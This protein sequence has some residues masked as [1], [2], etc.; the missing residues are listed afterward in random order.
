LSERTFE[1]KPVVSK[2]KQKYAFKNVA[3]VFR[4][5]PFCY[6]SAELL[7]SKINEF[8]DMRTAPPPPKEETVAPQVVIVK[9]DERTSS[10]QQFAVFDSSEEEDEGQELRV[11]RANRQPAKWFANSSANLQ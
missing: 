8:I 9:A 5:G 1:R 3:G 7:N 6:K 11:E 4:Q 2:H 10:P